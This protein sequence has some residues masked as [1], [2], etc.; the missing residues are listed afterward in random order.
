MVS[1]W[2]SAIAFSDLAVCALRYHIDGRRLL[3]FRSDADFQ[4][5]G[6]NGSG[7][8]NIIKSSLQNYRKGNT[9]PLG[10]L[11]PV[12]R[13][14]T[15]ASRQLSL[16]ALG[17]SVRVSSAPFSQPERPRIPGMIDGEN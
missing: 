9:P 2:L 14:P 6:I 16:A 17:Q 13:Q 15:Q 4:R 1:R 10:Q 11:P 7:I 5:I 12:L 3:S 8:I